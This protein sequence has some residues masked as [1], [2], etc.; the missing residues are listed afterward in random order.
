MLIQHKTAFVDGELVPIIED[1]PID[2]IEPLEMPD[3][4]AERDAALKAINWMLELISADGIVAKVIALRFVMRMENRSMETAG[5]AYGLTRAAISKNVTAFSD[6]FG[7]PAYKSDQ[8]RATYSRTQLK[9]WDTRPHK[10]QK[11]NTA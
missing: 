5:K 3:G 2:H 4:Q 9:V 8:A 10:N 1:H 7:V 6:A 11:R